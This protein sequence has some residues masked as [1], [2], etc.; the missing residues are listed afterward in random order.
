MNNVLTSISLGG[1]RNLAQRAYPD[2]GKGVIWTDD[3]SIELPVKMGLD[4]PANVT[5]ITLP[6]AFAK[7]VE[8]NHSLPALRVVSGIMCGC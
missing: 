2:H 8:R 7:S 5:P 4:Y 1:A 3:P 6:V